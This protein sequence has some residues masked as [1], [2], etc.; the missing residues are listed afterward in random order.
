V[1]TCPIITGIV[2]HNERINMAR[3]SACGPSDAVFFVA[4]HHQAYLQC[5][6][7][8]IGDFEQE[9]SAS[10]K[11]LKQSHQFH[12]LDRIILTGAIVFAEHNSRVACCVA[13]K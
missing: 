3:E 9:K 5:C 7:R 8:M 11:K 12:L 1:H 6:V 4:H 10:N 13:G 2:T